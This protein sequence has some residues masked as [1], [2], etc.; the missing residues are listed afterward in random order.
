MKHYPNTKPTIQPDN[1]CVIICIRTSDS[2]IEALYYED[3]TIEYFNECR[4]KL[5]V[6]DWIYPHEQIEAAKFL[7]QTILRNREK[8]N[9]DEVLLSEA[10]I[11]KLA[12]S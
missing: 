7:A 6:F 10:L 4:G 1:D 11:C 9:P 2:I 8:F 3:D 12:A 5:E